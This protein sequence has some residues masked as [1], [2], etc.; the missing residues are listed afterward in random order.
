MQIIPSSVQELRDALAEADEHRRPFGEANLSGLNRILQHTPEDLTCSAESGLSL[1][2][3]QEFLRSKNQWLPL[4]PPFPETLSLHQLIC[5]NPTG[6]RRAGYGT[7]RDY[8]IG[9]SVALPGGRLISA[10]GQVVKNV[11]GYDLCKLFVG[12]QGTLGI[13]AQAVFKLRPLPEA[14]CY[15]SRDCESFEEIR[16]CLKAIR[17]SPLLFSVLDLYRL[18]PDGSLTL[19]TGF[20]GT[21]A[22]V[23]VQRKVAARLGFQREIHLDYNER[24][25][26]ETE[27]CSVHSTSVLPT[28]LEEALVE[29][30]PERFVARAANGCIHF[31]GSKLPPPENVPRALMRR[32]KKTYD[33]HH[34]LP[35]YPWPKTRQ[36]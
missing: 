17:K 28:R 5:S 36:Q 8:L 10:G 3:L 33:P 12:S 22:E 18:S 26:A 13:V 1:A 6:P 21:A 7:V 9:V 29:L 27:D 14:E 19:V 35:D 20:D 2:R 11:A 30:E 24:F 31:C 32:I 25:F 15:L 23:E 16:Q 4:D 34:I